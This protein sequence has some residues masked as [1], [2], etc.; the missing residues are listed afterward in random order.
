MSFPISHATSL[1]DNRVLWA[2]ATA[3]VVAQSIK[4][5]RAVRLKRRFDM[6]WFLG[7]GGMPSAHSAGVSALA[8]AVGLEQGFHSPVFAIALMFALVTMFDAQ[9][10]RRA[11]G[12]QAMALNR[13]IDE[14][15]ARGQVSQERVLEMLGHTPTEVFVGALLGGVIAVLM[16]RF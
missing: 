8:V 12:R 1:L 3:W 13:M 14:L 11:T 6:R 15:Y 4:V 2:T 10:V 16:Y 7:T 9:G 5:A